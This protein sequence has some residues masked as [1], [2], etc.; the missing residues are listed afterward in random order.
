MR[1]I[2]QEK[3]YPHKVKG[4]GHFVALF[5]KIEENETPA[6][7]PL[8]K[9]QISKNSEQIYRD[10]EKQCFTAPQFPVL[11]EANGNVYGIPDGAFDWK[12]LQMLRVGVHL[13]EIKNGRFEPSQA[14]ALAVNADVC[15]NT[16]LLTGE[17]A[18]TNAYLRGETIQDEDENGWCVV[19]V[20]NC[21]LGFGK[22]VQ[23]T[24]KNHLPKGIRKRG[25]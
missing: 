5:E 18:R 6:F 22:R 21:T 9:A 4:E 10:F 23:G 25:E 20:D 2:K 19:C 7:V 13:G 3:L 15:K 17:D 16:V 12:G 14:L 8:A 11:H 24:V 1:L